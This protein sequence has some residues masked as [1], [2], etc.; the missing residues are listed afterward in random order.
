MTINRRKL[1]VVAV[2]PIFIGLAT[3][4]DQWRVLDDLGREYA[5]G[6]WNYSDNAYAESIGKTVGQIRDAERKRL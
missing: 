4:Q 5:V 3:W 1:V 2:L 6:I